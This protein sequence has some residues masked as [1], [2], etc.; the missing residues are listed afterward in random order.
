VRSFERDQREIGFA[1]L[2]PGVNAGQANA[3]NR[4]E[5]ATDLDDPN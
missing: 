1:L 5:A 2:D 4:A 3:R